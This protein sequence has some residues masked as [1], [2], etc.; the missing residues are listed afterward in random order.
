MIPTYYVAK[1]TRESVTVALSGDGGDELFGGYSHYL[2]TLIN[3]YL[4]KYVPKALRRGIALGSRLLPD[5]IPG[6]RQLLRLKYD[7]YDAYIDRITHLY[8]KTEYRKNLFKPDYLADMN[9]GYYAPE[10]I[11][12]DLL[13]H[14]PFDI[15]NRIGACDFKTY[16]PD[17]ILVKV[18]RASMFVSLEVRSPL[19]DY[20]LVEFAFREVPGTLKIKGRTQKYLLKRLAYK[21]LPPA[22]KLDRKWGFAIPIAD[23][24]RGPLYEEVRSALMDGLTEWVNRDFVEKMLQEHRSGIDHSGRLYT[25]LVLSHWAHANRK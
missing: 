4:S 19:L 1:A 7:P 9:A 22:L 18:D 25:L 5:S 8:F 10:R 23:W 13:E 6:K 21:L 12:R 24:F 20:R 16:L 14:I 15:V 2:G 3:Y 17:D 11:R